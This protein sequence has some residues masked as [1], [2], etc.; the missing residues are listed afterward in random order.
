METER[1]F[2]L[3]DEAL[4]LLISTESESD[5]DENNSSKEKNRSS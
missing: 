3:V 2:F 4:T 1:T 5:T